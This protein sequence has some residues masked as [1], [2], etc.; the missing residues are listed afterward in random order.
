MDIIFTFE[1]TL[2]L[3][4]SYIIFTKYLNGKIL[5]RRTIV[6]MMLSILPAYIL[7]TEKLYFILAIFATF[8]L[9]L[10]TIRNVKHSIIIYTIAF[11]Q[12]ALLAIT[13]SI[14]LIVNIF[15]AG[16]TIKYVID[17]IINIIISAFILYSNK[18]TTTSIITN[19]INSTGKGIKL[20]IIF[21]LFLSGVLSVIMSYVPETS[22][23]NN[24]YRVLSFLFISI[25][26]AT[27]LIYPICISNIIAKNY[28]KRIN[29]IAEQQIEQQIK[30]Y[31]NLS[32]STHSLREFK[33]NYKNMMIALDVYLN[34][35]DIENAKTFLH[36]CNTPI[37]ESNNFNTGNYVLDAMLYDKNCI[38][39]SHNI[40]I[41]F[42]GTMTFQQIDNIDLCLIF[43]NAIDNAIEACQQ[44]NINTEKTI[45]ISVKHLNNITT[46]LISNPV[47]NPVKI[48]NNTILSTKN[49]T[50]NHGFG[51]ETIKKTIQKYDGDLEISCIDNTFNLNLYLSVN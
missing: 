1:L 47:S 8:I 32:K 35:N 50:T 7:I 16:E 29:K 28:Y 12:A 5:I 46:I 31:S 9:P 22:T 41:S 48:Y 18:N 19:F 11:Y 30:Y 51:I 13:S 26:I 40:V 17:F 20:L 15:F 3:L 33:H 49:D 37:I 36:N 39:K 25:T 21:T 45:T 43:G 2:S 38:A 4:N 23:F 44:I 24:W 10:F 27:S 42:S 14:L 6:S 34:N